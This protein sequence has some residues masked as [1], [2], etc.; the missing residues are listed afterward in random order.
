MVDTSN[1]EGD[2]DG[3]T[4]SDD[5]TEDGYGKLIKNYG[6]RFYQTGYI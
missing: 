3:T 5:A 2:H 6:S 1:R 4:W